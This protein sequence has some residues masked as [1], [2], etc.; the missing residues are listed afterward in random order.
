MVA[1]SAVNFLSLASVAHNKYPGYQLIIA[2][3]RDLNGS[4]QNRAEAA[5]KACQCDI[6]LPPVF[7]DWNDA[8]ALTEEE[9]TRKAILEALKPHNASPFDTMSEA[10]FTAMSVSEKAQ[11]VQE[12]YRDALAVD[13]NG[14][15]YPAM[16]SGAWKVIS[17]SDFAEMSRPF[18]SASVRR[19]P[20]GE[21][22]LT[23][24]NIKVNCS[25]A[26]KSGT[27][28]DPVFVMASS[29][30]NRAV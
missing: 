8:L 24:G 6:V 9:S 5:A 22:C 13:P 2:A 7:G 18:S 14:Q 16:K 30:R 15:L 10:E 3:D 11:R 19:F 1:F 4:G 27:S 29:I 23:G 20:Q 17:Q 12:H 25:A 26:A 21:N 28:S